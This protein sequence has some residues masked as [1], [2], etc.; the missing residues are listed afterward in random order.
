MRGDKLLG[1]N[2]T[3]CQERIPKSDALQF[4]I[5][6]QVFTQ[7]QRYPGLLCDSPLHRVPKGEAVALDNSHRKVKACG[8]SGNHGKQGLPILDMSCCLSSGQL[9][10]ARDRSE[11]F[12]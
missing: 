10:F 12:T 11:K 7:E 3:F 8:R 1:Q 4:T 2:G 5:V 6:L 9:A